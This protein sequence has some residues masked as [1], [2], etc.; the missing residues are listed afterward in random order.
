[1]MRP[2]L[3]GILTLLAVAAGQPAFAHTRSQSMSH[4]TVAG[5]VLTGRIEAD[6]LDVTRL[7]ALGGEAPLEE[8]FR[9][10]AEGAFSV[11][12]AGGACPRVEPAALTAAAAGRVAA[13]VRFRCAPGALGRGQVDIRSSLFL[14]VAATH[15][16]FAAVT[17]ADGAE[18]EAV[19]TDNHRTARFELRRERA[20]ESWIAVLARYIPIGAMHVWTGLDHLAFILGL[21]LLARGLWPV[22]IAASGFTLGHTATL[23]LAALGVLHPAQGAVEALIGFTVAFVALEASPDG[24]ERLSRWS[25]PIGA[26]LLVMAASAAFVPVVA[27]APLALAGLALFVVSY[28]RGFP[29]GASAAPW[30]AAV[31]GLVHGCGFAGALQQLDLPRPH[32]LAALAGFNIGVELAQFAVIAAALATMAVTRRVFGQASLAARLPQWLCAALFAVGVYWFIGRSL[33]L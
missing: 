18:A 13:L 26:G 5:D 12:A 25:V 4:W 21:T 7:Y 9:R 15:L 31:F 29:R 30:L 16:H 23:L 19:L 27:V 11:S 1:M 3:L 24:P 22:L 33:V 10:E 28:P 20:A 14:N 32:L 17:G 6:A 8:T 2:F